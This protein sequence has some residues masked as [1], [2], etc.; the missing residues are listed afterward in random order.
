MDVRAV[1]EFLARFVVAGS[2]KDNNTLFSITTN[3]NLSGIK[4]GK[5][6]MSLLY[7][8][9]TLVV[10]KKGEYSRRVYYIDISKISGL[11]IYTQ[12]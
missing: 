7:D 1:E 11:E 5:D 8:S 2:S 3:T 10:E 4:P 12:D 6:E 9:T